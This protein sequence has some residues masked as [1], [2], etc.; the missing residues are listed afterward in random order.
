[1]MGYLEAYPE[2]AEKHANIMREFYDGMTPAW[3]MFYNVGLAKA[4][5]EKWAEATEN[6]NH[7][8]YYYPRFLPAAKY[9]ENIWPKAPLPQQRVRGKRVDPELLKTIQLH[10]TKQEEYVEVR[11]GILDRERRRLGV[12]ADWAYDSKKGV[13]AP[14]KEKEGEVKQLSQEALNNIRLQQSEIEKLQ[15][16]IENIIL[17]EKIKMNIPLNWMCSLEEGIF[18]S[19]KEFEQYKKKGNPIQAT[20]KKE[21]K[22][23]EEG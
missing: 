14:V 3:V 22:D 23:S 13:F 11:D 15:L 8:L 7:S 9:I 20:T 16:I 5:N 17:Q 10:R 19:P 1:M 12:P 6:F 21:G 4:A 18:L 2:H